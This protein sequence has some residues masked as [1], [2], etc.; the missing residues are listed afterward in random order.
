MTLAVGAA[1]EYCFSTEV[2]ADQVEFTVLERSLISGC[3]QFRLTVV[4]PDPTMGT[5][6]FEGSNVG[7][8]YF[9]RDQPLPQHGWLVRIE[10]TASCPSFGGR[11]VYDAFARSS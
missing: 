8:R 9:G 7:L 11:T 6:S 4:H 10:A 2:G 3:F 5:R 1:H